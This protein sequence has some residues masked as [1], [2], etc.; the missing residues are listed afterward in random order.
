MDG[1]DISSFL[2]QPN[3]MKLPERP[4]YYYARN[5]KLEAARLGKWKLHISKSSG[6]NSEKN[7]QFPVSL[8]NLEDDPSEMS[9]VVD[10]YPDIVKK[11]EAIMKRENTQRESQGLK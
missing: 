6:W 2:I 3:V 5:G 1:T 4:F 10:Q 11:I 9:N 8:F 7:G